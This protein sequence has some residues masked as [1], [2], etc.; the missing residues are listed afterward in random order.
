MSLYLDSFVTVGLVRRDTS[1]CLEM[2]PGVC[3]LQQLVVPCSEGRLTVTKGGR[4]LALH[5]GA[6]R[7]TLMKSMCLAKVRRGH[8]GLAQ[9]ACRRAAASGGGVRWWRKERG[10]SSW[11]LDALLSKPC[12]NAAYTRFGIR[13]WD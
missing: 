9:H 8:R 7:F 3:L 2:T 4:A 11:S 12:S 1:C 6:V 10:G 5:T 13:S